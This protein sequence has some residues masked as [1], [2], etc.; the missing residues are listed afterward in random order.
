MTA[1][2]LRLLNYVNSGE[3]GNIKVESLSIF[4]DEKWQQV[5]FYIDGNAKTERIKNLTPIPLTEKWL[6]DFGF[7]RSKKTA[8][9]TGKEVEYNVF[10]KYKLLFNEIQNQWYYDKVKVELSCVHE[11]Q[12]LY[13]ALTKEE[14]K[15]NKKNQTK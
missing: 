5:I 15:I 1:Q 12:N 14:L 6:I 11:L 8:Y 9:S 10:Y 4:S 2:E 13:F 3:Y 7:E